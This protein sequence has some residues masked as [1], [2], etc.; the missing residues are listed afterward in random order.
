M[1][2]IVS[3]YIIKRLQKSWETNHGKEKETEE[4]ENFGHVIGKD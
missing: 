2:I 1:E 4:R 3:S